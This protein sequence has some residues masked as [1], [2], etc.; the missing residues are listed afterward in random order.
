MY[1]SITGVKDNK[2]T[3]YQPFETEADAIA[4]A[5]QYNGF[6]VEDIGGNQE[7]WVVDA[8]AKT[9]TQDTVT[10]ASVNVIR[11]AQDEIRRLESTIT[12]RR[13]RDA[14]ANDAGKSWVAAVEAKIATERGK[15]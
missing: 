10:E 13:I 5:T 9:I 4:H 6:T 1:L 15:L 7:F 14:L 11:N 8:T 3:K 12:P 2:L